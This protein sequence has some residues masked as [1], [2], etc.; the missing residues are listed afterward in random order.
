MLLLTTR[1]SAL[2]K[3]G[4]CRGRRGSGVRREEMWQSIQ[5]GANAAEKRRDANA[6]WNV[7]FGA[8][9]GDEQSGDKA[10]ELQ[11]ATQNAREDAREPVALLDRRD[12]AVSI[13]NHERIGQH[14]YEAHKECKHS[15]IVE[16]IFLRR[17]LCLFLLL[18]NENVIVFRR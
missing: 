1:C 17:F 14:H 6:A 11:A 18:C 12:H 8:E 4:R 3:R 9:V 15:D 2:Y 7:R 16:S 10:A 5:Q 13:A